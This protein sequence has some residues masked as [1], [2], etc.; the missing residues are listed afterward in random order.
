MCKTCRHWEHEQNVPVGDCIN[1]DVLKRVDVAIVT[2]RDFGCRFHQPI[3][4]QHA[5]PAFLSPE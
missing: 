5:G 2:R 4:K 3:E 1:V